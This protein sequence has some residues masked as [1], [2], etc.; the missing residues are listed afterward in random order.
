DPFL[1]ILAEAAVQDHLRAA[2]PRGRDA[3]GDRASGTLWRFD[4]GHWTMVALDDH[5]YAFLNLRQNRIGIAGKIGVADVK[6]SHIHNDTSFAG[7]G[8]DRTR[9]CDLVRVKQRL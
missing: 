5:F 7:R 4:R 8:P 3:L 6:R 2:G 9:L 1:D